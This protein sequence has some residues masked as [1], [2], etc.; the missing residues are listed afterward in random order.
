MINLILTIVI[1]IAIMIFLYVWVV[2]KKKE[3]SSN[4]NQIKFEIKEIVAF[5]RRA[6]EEIIASSLYEG[7]PSVEE[8]NRRKARRREL[9]KALRSCMHGDI[10]AKKFVKLFMKDLLL[11][12]YGLNE[13]NVN[14]VIM[15]D[16]PERMSSQDQFEIL[17]HVFQKEHNQ[18]A[19]NKII[20]K[21]NLDELSRLSDGTKGYQIT[22]EQIREIYREERPRLTF[23]DKIDIIIQRVYQIYKG[24]GVIDELR[25]QNIDG[26]N[27]GT[28][29][30]PPDVVQNIDVADYL[31]QKRFIPR[32]YDA[33]WI[34]YR[35]KSI[36]LAFLGF[37]S[38]QELKRVCQN[39]YGF[40]NPG[41]LNE[42]RGY[43]IN[44]MADGSRV[45]VV[46]PKMAESW[47]FFVRKFNDSLVELDEQVKGDGADL[48]IRM[49]VYLVLG[50]QVTA[51]TGRQGSGKTTLLKALIKYI[52]A[53]NIRIQET[54]FEIWARKMYPGKNILS[55]R[56]TP[57][58][59]GQDGLDVQKKT[60]GSVN[61]VGEAATH[62]VVS[63]VIQA[64]QVAS[65]YTL[66]THHGKTLDKLINALRNSLIASGA[67]TNEK[68]AESQV[69]EAL[70]FN[71][72]LVLR[73]GKRYI[74]RITEV[75]PLE[76][77]YEYPTHYKDYSRMTEK[78][79]AFMDTMT[80]YFGRVTDRQSYAYR[81]VIV[82][83]D[84]RYVV[85]DTITSQKVI[86]MTKNMDDDAAD[87]FKA[88]LLQYWGESA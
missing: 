59:S 36:Q 2:L 71:V 78:L 62:S 5:M 4:N 60:D 23:Q 16:H 66:F 76:L 64:A 40:G 83:E 19:F 12:T 69:V 47:A 37:G 9:Q 70:G 84:G 75:I 51:I 63:Y 10:F 54:S 21:Y 24:L 61:I 86:E 13:T 8:F 67:F 29:G 74:E 17:L 42:S 44:D 56:E 68:I 15:F 53:K 48:A 30:M 45:V 32:S 1:L 88:F 52:D 7:S 34:F 46:R 14:A 26:V 49:L 3:V 81:D 35:G 18:E 87:Q 22:E 80:E 82:W 6:F 72:H 85:K 33:V 79:D 65:E 58:V 20:D 77:N 11:G 43:I 55:F 41:Q 28:S 38:E 57:T 50:H 73:S 39:I 31:S 27:G 25:D